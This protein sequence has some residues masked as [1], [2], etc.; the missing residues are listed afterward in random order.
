M[1]ICAIQRPPSGFPSELTVDDDVIYAPSSDP[2]DPVNRGFLPSAISKTGARIV[3][4]HDCYQ[5]MECLLKNIP[6]SVGLVIVEHNTPTIP[7]GWP[8]DTVGTTLSSRLLSFVRAW[9][10]ERW[11]RR[12][13]RLLYDICDRYVLLSDRY[14]G[15]FRWVARL[16]DTRKLRAIPNVNTF[17]PLPARPPKHKQVLFLGSLL[18]VKGVDFL[19]EAW[20][21]V[22]RD[23]QD[24]TLEIVGDGPFRGDLERK[25]KNRTIPRIRFHGPSTDVSSFL[26]GAPILAAPSRYEGFPM[27][28]GEAMAHGTVPVC[29]DSYS[30]L[31]DIVTDGKDGILVP[32]FDVAAFAAALR[33]LMSDETLL[34]EMFENA[35][36]SVDRFSAENVIPMWKALFREVMEEKGRAG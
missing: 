15:E 27:V 12:R 23:F 32:A 1:S 33:R 6:T 17:V 16:R 28:L 14:F 9:R 36:R 5:P 4:F 13:H 25:A 19:L 8:D 34:H 20:L 26:T 7:V 31:R 24:W 3:V 29:F 18:R 10:A 2:L 11:T 30:A 22:A 35:L 21:Y